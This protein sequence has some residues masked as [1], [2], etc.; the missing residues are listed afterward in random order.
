MVARGGPVAGE[1]FVEAGVWPE[2]DEAGEN[3]GQ[4]VNRRDPHATRRAPRLHR[5]Q[6]SGSD[7]QE[8]QARRSCNVNLDS[9]PRPLAMLAHKILIV[10][11]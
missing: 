5:N 4:V 10:N 7:G 6:H 3:V 1:E 11:V 2:I 9:G 8:P